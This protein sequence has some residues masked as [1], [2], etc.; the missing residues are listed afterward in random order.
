MSVQCNGCLLFVCCP[1]EGN[2]ARLCLEWYNEAAEFPAQRAC[3]MHHL[4]IEKLA[5]AVSCFSSSS[6]FF[7]FV[8]NVEEKDKADEQRLFKKVE[9]KR[10]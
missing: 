4:G 3:V 1:N 2:L 10:Q 9:R 6:R 5:G 7:T 8:A